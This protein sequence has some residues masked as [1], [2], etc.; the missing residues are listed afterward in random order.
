[1]DSVYE[2]HFNLCSMLNVMSNCS[3]ENRVKMLIRA[4]ILDPRVL[5]FTDC[6]LFV[7]KIVQT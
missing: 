2:R 5:I 7:N 3:G 4:R 6:K 1:V